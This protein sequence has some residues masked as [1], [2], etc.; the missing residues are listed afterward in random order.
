M[1]FRNL[2]N[3]PEFEFTPNIERLDHFSSMAGVKTKDKSVVMSKAGSLRIQMEELT[4]DNLANAV[5]GTIETQTDG[6]AVVNIMDLEVLAYKVRFTGTNDVGRKT[7]WNFERVEFSP[8]AAINPISD[9]WMN[10]EITG[11]TVA[12]SGV[13]G[14]IEFPGVGTESLT[15]PDVLNYTIGKGTVEMELIP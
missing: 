4:A 13:F 1:T 5:M 12:V 8:S 3:C 7:I 2:G 9:E 15:S 6:D 14:N 10:F 11:E